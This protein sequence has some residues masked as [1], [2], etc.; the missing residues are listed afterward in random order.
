MTFEAYEN[1]VVA[2]VAS[3][4]GNEDWYRGVVCDTIQSSFWNEMSVEDAAMI[5]EMETAFQDGPKSEDG[6]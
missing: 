5:A 6:W 3:R 2:L 1:A 4:L